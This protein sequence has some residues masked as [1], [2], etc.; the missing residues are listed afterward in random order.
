MN[1][2]KPEVVTWLEG[3]LR[4]A[5]VSESEWD[6]ARKW[7]RYYLD[8]CA[9]YG[10]SPRSLESI[11]PFLNKLQAKGQNAMSREAAEATIRLLLGSQEAP[12]TSAKPASGIARISG[13]EKKPRRPVGGESVVPQASVRPESGASWRA[14][15]EK[16]TGAIRMRNYSPTTLRTY[17]H[18]VAKFQAFVYSK[19]PADLGTEDV[20]DFLTD[21]AVRHGVAASTQPSGA[22]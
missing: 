6:V 20:K 19:A 10:L 16:L 12:A 1:A 21:L 8:F 15:F 3:R 18:W 22:R 5:S 13:G 14:E 11:G 9:K 7:A 4:R 17:R 2:L